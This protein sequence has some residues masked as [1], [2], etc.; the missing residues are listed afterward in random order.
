[1]VQLEISK[2]GEGDKLFPPGFMLSICQI[3]NL[4]RNRLGWRQLVWQPALVAVLFTSKKFIRQDTSQQYIY[5][6]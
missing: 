3:N 4:G 5:L 1:M 6:K 2:G